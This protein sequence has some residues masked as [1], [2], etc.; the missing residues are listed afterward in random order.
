MRGSCKRGASVTA[1]PARRLVANA[2]REEPHGR[3]LTTHYRALAG[4]LSPAGLF[5][6]HTVSGRS[7]APGRSCSL[8]ARSSTTSGAASGSAATARRE[9]ARR[10]LTCRVVGGPPT[11]A[12]R[13]R[14]ASSRW[15]N[16]RRRG[17]SAAPRD[18]RRLRANYRRKHRPGLR[19]RRGD[20]RPPHRSGHRRDPPRR[21]RSA[22]PAAV[23]GDRRSLAAAGAGRTRRSD[24]DRKRAGA[25]ACARGWF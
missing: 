24:R 10:S 6:P 21:G 3:A 4:P 22:Q 13:R 12:T 18:P 19:R 25:G 5:A 9:P 11:N 16:A 23:P 14:P 15:R 1:P 2:A 7:P 17:G 8:A 20:H